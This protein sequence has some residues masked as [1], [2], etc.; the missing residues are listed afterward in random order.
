MQKRIEEF[1]EK[2]KMLSKGDVVIAGVSG[3]ADSVCLLLV[4]DEMK[5]SMGFELVAVHVN[6]GIRGAAAD[7]DEAF[8][9]RIC[10]ERKIPCE[11]FRMDVRGFAREQKLSEEEAGREMR[12][13]AFEQALVKYGGTRIALAHHMEDNAETFFLHLARGSRLKGLGGIYPV[14]GKYIRPLLCVS[15]K[16]IEEYLAK[17]NIQYCMDI[18]NLEDTYTRNRIRNHVIPYFREQINART[19]E[20]VNS[21]MEQL[22]EIQCYLERRMQ[23]ACRECVCGQ[24]GGFLIKCEEF[25]RQEE[26]IQGM[27]VRHVLVQTAGREK[28]LEHIHVESVKELMG[29]QTGRTVDL[30]YGMRAV[31]TYEGVKISSGKADADDGPEGILLDFEASEGETYFGEWKVSYRIFEKPEECAEV[32]KKKYTK[33]FD[34]DIIK[35]NVGVRTRR[36]GDRIVVGSRGESQKLKSYFVNE[37]IPAGKRDKIP[38][39]V[40]DDRVLWIV[41]YRQSKAYQVTEQTA[42]IIEITMVNGGT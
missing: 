34:Y 1:V 14:N 39:I 35:H 21:A 42:T 7:A 24:D 36:A 37:K 10:A 11:A 19:V 23:E 13:N 12:K 2:W 31:R 28:D 32:P 26:L 5:K 38:L 22:R 20:H 16:D 18:T 17:R 30:P 33:W 15:R 4:L 8:V 25:G 27:V 40:E 9:K 29:K 3:G 41:G 6:H